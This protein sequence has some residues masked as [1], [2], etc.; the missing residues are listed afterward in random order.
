MA[1]PKHGT[2]RMYRYRKCRCDL[3]RDAEAERKARYAPTPG[4]QPVGKFSVLY[5]SSKVRLDPAPLVAYIHRTQDIDTNWR[6]RIKRWERNGIDVY[7]ADLWCIK[8][9]L[10]PT[11]LFG[12]DFYQ[13]CE[14]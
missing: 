12:D 14:L 13:G 2:S 7:Q 5:A 9:G 10:H 1:E 6:Q 11:A 4:D 8:L 3:C